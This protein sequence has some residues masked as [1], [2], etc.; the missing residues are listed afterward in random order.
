MSVLCRGP[1]GADVYYVKGAIEH[2]LSRCEQYYTREDDIRT[3][4]HEIKAIILGR[5]TQMSINGLRVL[6]M[7]YGHDRDKLIFVGFA[8]MYDP[9]R[10]GVTEAVKQLQAGGVRIVMITGD[11]EGTACAIA[12]QVGIPVS[13]AAIMSGTQVEQRSEQQLADVISSISVFYRATP[14]CKLAIV[15]ALQSRGAVVAMTGDGVNDS[16]VN[17]LI[18]SQFAITYRHI[19]LLRRQM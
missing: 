15:T 13:S 14:R 3:L 18:K 16:P 1:E 7:A 6:S 5:A 10:P 8:A 2:V 11:S 12:R 9:P 17:L 4:N 19:R